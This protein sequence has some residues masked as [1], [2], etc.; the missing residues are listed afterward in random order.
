MKKIA[1]I[2]KSKYGATRRYAEWVAEALEAPLFE[3]SAVNPS[4]L[5][6]YDIVIYGGGLYAGGVS[7]VKLVTKNACKSLIV[8]TV[9]LADPE[10]TDYTV[11]VSKSFTA[12]QLA[13][14]KVFHWRGGMDY[15]EL[16]FIDRRLMAMVKKLA[17]KKTPEER[18]SE[19]LGI[20]ESYGKKVDFTDK[21]VIAPLIEYVRSL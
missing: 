14:V 5:Q 11:V 3:A 13:D 1:V 17:E 2:Y 20:I 9:G 6:E 12:E 21:S 8:F 7:G 10:I 19:D 18:T 16:G 15:A 4:Q